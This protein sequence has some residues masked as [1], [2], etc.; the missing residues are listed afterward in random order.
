[1]I[2]LMNNNQKILF[3]CSGVRLDLKTVAE[4][5]VKLTSAEEVELAQ[6]LKNEYG[7][8]GN[9]A[10]LNRNEALE[11]KLSRRERRKL[12]R[13]ARKNKNRE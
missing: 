7:I 10:A 12:A 4:D 9:P 2:M 8:E 5:L 3:S 1:M 6:L 11:P 13:E